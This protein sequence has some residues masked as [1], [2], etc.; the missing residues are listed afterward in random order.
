VGLRA[1]VYW[2]S[3]KDPKRPRTLTTIAKA[4][5]AK[6]M[7]FRGRPI[8]SLPGEKKFHSKIN[9]QEETLQ[10]TRELLSALLNSINRCSNFA[11]HKQD[12]NLFFEGKEVLETA[13]KIL[14]EDKEQAL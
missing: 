4:Y 5:G 10:S 11:D 2:Y 7:S 8:Y 9:H 13:T 1:R 6:L 3:Q 14:L 12:L